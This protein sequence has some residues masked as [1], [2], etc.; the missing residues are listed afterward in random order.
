MI[1]KELALRD[2]SRRRRSPRAQTFLISVFA[3]LIGSLE[4]REG[5]GWGARTC[6]SRLNRINL[7]VGRRRRIVASAAFPWLAI[8]AIRA[9]ARSRPLLGARVEATL[10]LLAAL[11]RPR[12]LLSGLG[13]FWI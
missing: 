12:G 5:V 7:A 2:R 11:Q 4:F 3:R 9:D 10:A 8:R 6:G 13:D 1:C